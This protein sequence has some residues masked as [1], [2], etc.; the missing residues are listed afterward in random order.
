MVSSSKGVKVMVCVLD[1][2]GSHLFICI[3]TM[4]PLIKDT[5]NKAHFCIKDAF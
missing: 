5:L 1:H 2:S 4:E 3:V